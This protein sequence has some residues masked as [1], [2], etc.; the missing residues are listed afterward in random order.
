[1]K[2][3]KYP[4]NPILSPH[5]RHPWENLVVCNPGVIYDRGT[6]YMLY[7]CAGEDATHFIHFGLAVSRDGFHFR[8]VSTQPILSP[9]ADGEDG[10]CI[11]DPRIVKMN[12]CFFITYAY[13]PY[14]PGQYWLQPGNA[15]YNPRKHSLPKAFGQNLT[16][17]G[18]LIP[19]IFSLP[20]LAPM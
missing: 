5:A 14:P 11:E 15:A 3:I 18:L 16:C 2:L 19:R 13:R 1:M 9:S 7:R 4:H 17:S 6:F 20:G 8:R 10:G 12:G